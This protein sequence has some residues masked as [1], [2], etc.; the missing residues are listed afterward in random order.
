MQQRD[1]VSRRPVFGAVRILFGVTLFTALI[2]GHIGFAKLLHN[3][4]DYR[5]AP[6]D[7]PCYDP[8]LFVLGADPEGCNL[9]DRVLVW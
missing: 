5:H 4:S 6:W 7:L 8:Q 9:A 3:R 2:L 1:D